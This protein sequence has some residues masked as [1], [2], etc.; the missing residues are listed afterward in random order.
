MQEKPSKS[1]GSLAEPL[2][3]S[4]YDMPLA[5]QGKALNVQNDEALE[6]HL[7]LDG[8]AVKD[9]DSETRGDC[10]LHGTVIAQ[11]EA[12]LDI[13]FLLAKEFFG[14]EASAGSDFSLDKNLGG[15]PIYRDPFRPGQAMGGGCDDH[16]VFRKKGLSDMG[17]PL[18]GPSHDDEVDLV[19][20]EAMMHGGTIGDLQADRDAGMRF[21]K[22]AEDRRQYIS[23]SGAYG[24]KGDPSSLESLQLFHDHLGIIKQLVH[25]LR[26]RKQRLTR[27][28]Q[29]DVP[30]GPFKKRGPNCLLKLTD[31]DGDCGL[32]QIELLGSPGEAAMAGNREKDV[33]LVYG[34][35]SIIMKNI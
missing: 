12:A 32:T 2:L 31:L 10:F 35:R 5:S 29:Q 1:Q 16:Q 15:E 33:K 30:A 3:L 6:G 24:R 17:D 11:L 27:L 19:V 4:V 20:E 34:H 7:H 23:P 28:G 26:I 13:H 25:S 14:G 22:G 8:A 18:W 9:G 21:P